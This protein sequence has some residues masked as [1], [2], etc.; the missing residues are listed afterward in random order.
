VRLRA[1]SAAATLTA[2]VFGV[3]V[4]GAG[5]AEGCHFEYSPYVKAVAANYRHIQGWSQRHED[6]L[7]FLGWPQRMRA[8]M[9]MVADGAHR[10]RRINLGVPPNDEAWTRAV[11]E[12]L[13]GRY[14]FIRRDNAGR[15]E[16][17]TRG[18]SM[19]SAVDELPGEAKRRI[20]E[21]VWF[22]DDDATR[23]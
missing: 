16:L 8:I 11:I 17:T 15:Y 23:W 14:C 5:A 18:R 4:G 20:F 9:T 21:A 10:V 12:D 7:E 19:L 3:P 22:G 1:I 2:V 6:A 13:A